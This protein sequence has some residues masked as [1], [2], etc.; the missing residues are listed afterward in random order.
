MCLFCT[1]STIRN[2]PLKPTIE[3]FLEKTPRDGVTKNKVKIKR[4]FKGI[5]ANKN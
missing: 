4:F 1:A 5:I 3:I 2:W